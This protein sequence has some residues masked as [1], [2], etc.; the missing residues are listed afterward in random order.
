MEAVRCR[1][2]PVAAISKSPISTSRWKARRDRR[3][4]RG[5]DRGRRGQRCRQ[6]GAGTAGDNGADADRKVPGPPGG[7]GPKAD[8]AAGAAGDR[9]AGNVPGR[10]HDRPAIS[11]G[12]GSTGLLLHTGAGSPGTNAP[13][14][15]DL[16]PTVQ[17]KDAILVTGAHSP[18]RQLACTGPATFIPQPTSRLLR[19][20][21]L[22]CRVATYTGQQTAR[23]TTTRPP[24]R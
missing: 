3:G 13:P 11:P 9:A 1:S 4:R 17:R 24:T 22:P 14:L 2:R 5:R 18:K 16:T 21:R 20:G 23:S 12:E 8:G 15:M 6:H 7:T 10:K 19:G